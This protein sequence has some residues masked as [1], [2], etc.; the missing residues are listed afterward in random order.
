MGSIP[1][2]RFMLPAI[3]C[4]LHNRRNQTEY[5]LQNADRLSFLFYLLS[6]YHMALFDH[7][8]QITFHLIYYLIMIK[9]SP[10][11]IML[12][13]TSVIQVDTP[14]NC[15][16]PIAYTH[17]CMGKSRCIFINTNPRLQQ[18]GIVALRN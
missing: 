4:F 12:V 2:L 11:F 15:Y 10:A 6:A 14:D 9:Y 8:L 18:Y 3:F 13:Q 5:F 1:Y 7:I 17:F 16:F